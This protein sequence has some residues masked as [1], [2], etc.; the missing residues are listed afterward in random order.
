M[1]TIHK[2]F[3]FE[4]RHVPNLL[5]S[6]LR[7][8]A[9]NK[10]VKHYSALNHKINVIDLRN[11][12]TYK[13][14]FAEILRYGYLH[15]NIPDLNKSVQECINFASHAHNELKIGDYLRLGARYNFLITTEQKFEDLV[16]KIVDKFFVKDTF[17]RIGNVHDIGNFAIRIKEEDIDV[18][19]TFGPMRKDEIGQF[20][21]FEYQDDPDTFYFFDVDCGQINIAHPRISDFINASKKH[22][23]KYLENFKREME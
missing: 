9:F 1:E 2:R 14:I 18:N 3:L 4:G 11:F 8:R 20:V 17:T 13:K 10:Y 23:L 5:Y 6:S 19:I 12:Q 16:N 22:A 15:E 21:E 7:D